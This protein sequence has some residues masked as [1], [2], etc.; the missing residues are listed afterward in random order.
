VTDF[1]KAW[2]TKGW[3]FPTLGKTPVAFSNPWKTLG[4]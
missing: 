2:K 4:A 3:I 1:S